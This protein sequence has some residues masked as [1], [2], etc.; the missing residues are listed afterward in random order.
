MATATSSKDTDA[1]KRHETL[2]MK[3]GNIVL[4]TDATLYRVHESVLEAQSSFF[5]GMFE[6]PGP[7]AE[8]EGGLEE[9]E[10]CRV[11]KMADDGDEDV[12]CLLDAVYS[13]RCVFPA[14]P[15]CPLHS[16]EPISSLSQLRHRP[17]FNAVIPL[18]R[19]SIKYDFSNI[20]LEVLRALRT[21]YPDTL[22]ALISNFEYKKKERR[23]EDS[24]Y[25]NLSYHNI[26]T[27]RFEL[28]VL[29]LRASET[30]T[31]AQILIP[32]LCCTIMSNSQTYSDL[33]SYASPHLSGSDFFKFLAQC[34]NFRRLCLR[35][36][37]CHALVDASLDE[38][39]CS[40][41]CSAALARGCMRF[42]DQQLHC[43]VLMEFEQRFGGEE[44]REMEVV[45][46][47]CR[48]DLKI[49]FEE[50]RDDLWEDLPHCFGLPKWEEMRKKWEDG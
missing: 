4:A 18:L 35:D 21:I 38:Y 1:R 8:N 45:C 48:K 36:L 25:G 43:D 23:V 20:L 17:R 40:S 26:C 37:T 50:A 9:Y 5:K 22:A 27:A 30:E 2:W 12:S 14:A 42:H 39:M 44:W 34:E 47:D 19:L 32:P 46:K 6:M 33:Y 41:D 28:L 49:W 31:V 11:V 7:L 29:L 24:F 10:G 15:F 13:P 16:D 3:D